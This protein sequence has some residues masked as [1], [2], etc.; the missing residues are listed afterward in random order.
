MTEEKKPDTR[1]SYS[2]ATLLKNCSMKY[3]HHKVANTARDPDAEQNYDAFNVGKAFHFVM[4]ENN[5]SEDKLDE[6]LTAACKAFE[7]EEHEGMLKA[8]LL[9]YLQVHKKSGLRAIMCELSLST[10]LFIGFIDVILIDDKTQEWW[11]ADLKTAARYSPVT[12][13]KLAQDTQLNLYCSF[14]QEIAETAGLGLDFKKFMGA[15][16]RVTTKSALKRKI[17]ESFREHVLRTAKN[18]KSY[19]V[20]VPKEIMDP[21]G[22]FAEHKKLHAKTLR[23]RKGTLKPEMNRSYCDSFF[24]PCEFWSQ[25]HGGKTYTECSTLLKAITTDNLNE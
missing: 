13:A 7:V 16:Y 24:K 23:L 17:T 5:H 9:R 12:A 2:S 3:Y 10:P 25:C 6:L 22:F 19:D 18:V 4:E 15:R 21:Q 14:A 20:I 8:M 11:I 1:L